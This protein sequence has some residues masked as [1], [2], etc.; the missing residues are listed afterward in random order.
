[1]SLSAVL[2][3]FAFL[4]QKLPV[5]A[6][7]NVCS[8]SDIDARREVDQGIGLEIDARSWV[9]CDELDLSILRSTDSGNKLS[10]EGASELSG[11]LKVS[12]RMT[13]LKLTGNF[14]N[15][16]GA[17]Q[18]AEA[19]AK[20]TVLESIWLGRNNIS[21]VGFQAIVTALQSNS[22][23]KLR[24]LK[25]E[26]NVIAGAGSLTDLLDPSQTITALRRVDMQGNQLDDTGMDMLALSI[27]QPNQA[28]EELVLSDNYITDLGAISLASAIAQDP[29]SITGIWLDGN[30]LTNASARSLSDAL[31]TNSHLETLSLTRT[32][33]FYSDW[34]DAIRVQFSMP[35]FSRV[36]GIGDFD[37]ALH[38]AQ[39]YTEYPHRVDPIIT[40]SIA[41]CQQACIQL[42]K[43]GCA[44]VEWS[45]E[46]GS[47]WVMP[48]ASDSNNINSQ[49]IATPLHYLCDNT[50]LDYEVLTLQ[51]L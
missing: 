14:I 40:S 43:P 8:K 31:Q 19:L 29:T 9:Q 32:E 38:M 35:K 4:F 27:V 42:R 18:I 33:A 45:S 46:S 10:V 6:S 24:E 36:H 13:R 17:A 7:N 26:F 41:E 25:L 23:S 50:R 34:G 30:D 48:F 28:L 1:M 20:N 16:E 11:Y 2:T 22:Y 44:G 12:Q 39:P 37:C 3:L 51:E 21:D 5:T 49:L 47:C 15:D